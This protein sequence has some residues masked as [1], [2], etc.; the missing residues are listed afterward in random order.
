MKVDISNDDVFDGRQGYMMGMNYGSSTEIADIWTKL[1]ER[2]NTGLIIG[3]PA[4]GQ[5]V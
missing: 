3:S 5:V 4:L 2:K 1:I